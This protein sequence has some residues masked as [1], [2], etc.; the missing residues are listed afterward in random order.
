MSLRARLVLATLTGL[1]LSGIVHLAAV[2]MIPR[3]GERD[4]VSRLAVTMSSDRSE[5]LTATQEGGR[6]LPSP[7]PAVAVA[8]CAYDLG[9]GPVRVAARTGSMFE[10]IAFHAKGGA[11][12][13]AV[14]DR[15]ATRGS[16]S[17]VVMTRQQLDDALAEEDEA[18][19]SRDVRIVSPTA[20]GMVVVR[21]LAALPSLKAEAEAAAQAVT[22]TVDAEPGE[23]G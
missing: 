6:W 11:V 12:F 22:C 21:T 4:A 17:L 19:T 5:L 10:S 1:V 9:E 20:Q 3:L 13:F 8:A 2:L 15:A 14:T 7:D 23:Q 16:L 18:E